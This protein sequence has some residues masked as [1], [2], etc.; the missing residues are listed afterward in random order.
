MWGDEGKRHQ[1]VEAIHRAMSSGDVGRKLSDGSRR[2]W[3]DPEYRAKYPADHHRG[4][5]AKLWSDPH[6]REFHRTKMKRQRE[7]Q[8]FLD[9]MSRGRRLSYE[10][11]ISLNPSMMA[12]MSALAAES[13][14]AKWSD[15]EYRRRGNAPEDRGLRL[16]AAERDLS[17]GV[18]PVRL[19]GWP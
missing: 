19:R 10:R 2:L 1:I 11:R 4:M 9:A 17:F 7:D 16:E 13:L 12:D 14:T 3:E 8:S 5:A 15:P 18:Q 6:A